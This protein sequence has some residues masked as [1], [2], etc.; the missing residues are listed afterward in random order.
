MT[1]L[2]RR[3]K[4][5]IVGHERD[6]WTAEAYQRPGCWRC[7]RCAGWFRVSE[8]LGFE[9]AAILRRAGWSDSEID[10]LAFRTVPNSEVLRF[11]RAVRSASGD[12]SALEHYEQ[13]YVMGYYAAMRDRA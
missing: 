2:L 13:G 7:V 12:P 10:G 6:T 9:H 3:V 1:G 4:C 11:L 8:Q 5:R